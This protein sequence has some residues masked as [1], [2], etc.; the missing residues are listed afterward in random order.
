[1]QSD[2]R[3]FD[4]VPSSTQR[5]RTLPVRHGKT[6]KREKKGKRITFPRVREWARKNRTPGCPDLIHQAV[7]FAKNCSKFGISLQN[8][9]EVVNVSA[10]FESG[11]IRAY[12]A[13]IAERKEKRLQYEMQATLKRALTDKFI[14]KRNQGPTGN[15]QVSITEAQ[16]QLRE[17]M[18]SCRHC[19]KQIEDWRYPVMAQG[20][21]FCSDDCKADWELHVE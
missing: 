12:E 4:S 3:S 5:L 18:L 2:N 8:I 17:Q 21:V 15:I 9:S 20:R 1:M 14:E 6:Q 11:F 13:D 19:G 7:T 10:G 16:K